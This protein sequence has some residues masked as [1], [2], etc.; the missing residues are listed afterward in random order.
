MSFQCIKNRKILCCYIS[1]RT[2]DL[3]FSI[4]SGC[5]VIVSII[6][7]CRF[8]HV[9][10]IHYFISVATNNDQTI[11]RYLITGIFRNKFGTYNR[12]LQFNLHMFRLICIFLK[13]ITDSF[14]LRTALS[15]LIDGNILVQIIQ[16]FLCLIT[17]TVQLLIT[18]I[19][20]CILGWQFSY[21]HVDHYHDCHKNHDQQRTVRT[22][23]QIFLIKRHLFLRFFFCLFVYIFS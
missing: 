18:N 1:N 2:C 9:I 8:V 21:D 19:N 6:I 23:P 15:N 7:H 22:V 12:I 17:N 11:R 13:Q 16:D 20:L 10:I 5:L 14:I 3:S 4:K